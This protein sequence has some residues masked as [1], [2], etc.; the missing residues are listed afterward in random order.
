[1][2]GNKG[3]KKVQNVPKMQKGGI[4]GNSKSASPAAMQSEF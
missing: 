3:R 1:M 2:G 4:G